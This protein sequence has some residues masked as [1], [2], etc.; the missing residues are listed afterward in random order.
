MDI[1]AEGGRR[2]VLEE[3]EH[4][5]IRNMFDFIRTHVHEVMVPRVKIVSLNAD[6]PAEKIF[7]AVSDNLYSRY[8]VY[9]ENPEN[10]AGIVHAKDLMLGRMRLGDTFDINRVIR[11]VL[12][13]PEEEE[14]SL[15]IKDMQRRHNQMAVVVDEYGGISGLITVEDL[16]EE[17]VGEIE[18]EFDIGEHRVRRLP[19]G[20]YLLDALMPIWDVEE[21]LGL[22]VR[23]EHD[24]NTLAGLILER[25]G[26]FPKRGEQIEWEGYIL[27]LEE[28][29]SHSI[30]RVRINRKAQPV[31]K[32]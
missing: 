8:P 13:V 16:L 31:G 26:Y 2:G 3:L 29:T 30:L 22:E 27:T 9:R 25:L 32:K 23:E 28:V 7:A 11:P 12:F 20:G 6:W 18:D 4:R 14:V 24:F 19:N 15:L 17:L 21:L 10:I 1:V 5:F